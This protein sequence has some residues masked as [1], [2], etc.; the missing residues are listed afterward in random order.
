MTVISAV[1]DEAEDEEVVAVGNDLATAF[2]DELLVLH[3]MTD[4]EYDNRSESSPDYYR[5]SAAEDAESVAER[6]ISAA[7]GEDVPATVTAR[8]RVGDPVE[9]IL[10]EVESRDARYLVIGGRK[11]TPVGKAVFGSITQSVLLNAEAP[12]MTVMHD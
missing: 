7:L 9:E 6:M 12:V 4:D 8:G 1:D 5:D 11:R 10:S 2:D 3:V